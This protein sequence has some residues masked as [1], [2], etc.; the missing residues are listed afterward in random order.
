MCLPDPP[1][2]P[3]SGYRVHRGPPVTVSHFVRMPDQTKL[4]LIPFVHFKRA[5]NIRSV[6]GLKTPANCVAIV[7]GGGMRVGVGQSPTP[8]QPSS[9]LRAVLPREGESLS[10]LPPNRNFIACNEVPGP[11]DPKTPCVL[12]GNNFG[13]LC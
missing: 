6:F 13:G 1:Y 12:G 10:S 8:T 5:S 7:Q 2:Q 11:L 9:W 4:S 3:I